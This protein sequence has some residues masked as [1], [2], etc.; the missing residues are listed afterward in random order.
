MQTLKL[1]LP[2]QCMETL[3]ADVEEGDCD[4]F[5]RSSSGNVLPTKHTSNNRVWSFN[6]QEQ[7]AVAKILK[8]ERADLSKGPRGRLGRRVGGRRRTTRRTKVD[9][10]SMSCHR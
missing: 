8:M 5:K 7:S 9:T 1:K 3:L 10:Q 6:F 2:R 4:D